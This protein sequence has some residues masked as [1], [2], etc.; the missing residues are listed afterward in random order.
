M[1]INFPDSPNVND[2]YT[3]GSTTWTW[4]GTSWGSSTASYSLPVATNTVLGGVKIDGTTVTIDV[5]GV[6]SSTATGDVQKA[7]SSADN[8]IVRFDGTS[9]DTLQ[10]SSIT[11]DDNGNLVTT[12][13]L[14]Y[15]NVFADFNTLETTVNAS[16]YHGMFAHAHTEGHAYFAHAGDWK[17][18]LDTDTVL[19]DLFDTNIN[20][21]QSGQFLKWSGTQWINDD[22]STSGTLSFSSLET[23]GTGTITLDSASTLTLTAPD[24]ITANGVPLPS[25]GGKI[26]LGTSPTWAGS[27]DISVSTTTTVG[28]PTGEYTFTF[29]NAYANTTDYIV[30]VTHNEWISTP[31]VAFNVVKSAGSFEIT[32]QRISTGDPVDQG[33]VIVLVYEF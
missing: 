29:T 19:N 8:A 33:E 23:S 12:G 30:S 13:Q 28:T 10:N 5:N 25:Y 21:V 17:Q 1:A 16:T 26:T 14:W 32:F 2:D 4:D 27:T 20:T 31:D 9:G 18:I 24:G 6:I 15:A 11:V 22:F 3:V 7:A